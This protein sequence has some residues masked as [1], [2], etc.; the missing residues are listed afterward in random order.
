MREVYRLNKSELYLKLGERKLLLA[1]IY[2]S[3]KE[4]DYASIEKSIKFQLE[5]VVAEEKS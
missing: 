3:R 4:E 1:F 2:L 5:M